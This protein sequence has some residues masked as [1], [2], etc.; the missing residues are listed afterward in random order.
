M[1]FHDPVLDV[2]WQSTL[3]PPW[4]FLSLQICI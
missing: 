3:Q 2:L 4:C 1:L